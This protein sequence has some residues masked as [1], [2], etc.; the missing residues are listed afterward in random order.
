MPYELPQFAVVPTGV[1]SATEGPVLHERAE[2]R[3][4]AALVHCYVA[5]AEPF[6][7]RLLCDAIVR[8]ASAVVVGATSD[9]RGMMREVQDL[10]PDALFLDARMGSDLLRARLTCGTP[11]P[12]CVVFVS[13]MPA[14]AASAFAYDATDFMLKPCSRARVVAALERVRRRM[15]ERTL[16][17]LASASESAPPY[18]ASAECEDASDG[19]HVAP[20]ADILVVVSR[21][22]TEYL[23][24]SAIHSIVAVGDI[25]R[26][27]TS[28]GIIETSMP[29][30][31]IER[32][33]NP[34]EFV[35]IHR[36]ALVN[37]KS[38][39]RLEAVGVGG[40]KLWLHSG[41]SL[42]VS[43]RRMAAVRRALMPGLGVPRT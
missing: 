16:I 36:C 20:Q 35:R 26:I 40:G 1:R 7:R 37:V 11:F 29:L 34:L 27:A 31:E 3:S 9:E 5:D 23:P 25:N 2:S 14:D 41:I 30:F 17:A 42:P 10:Q 24:S 15:Q 32:R 39:R 12:C 43:K 13:A 19:Q 18:P 6:A 8:D 22:G 38:V 4:A 21:R 33:L 28:D